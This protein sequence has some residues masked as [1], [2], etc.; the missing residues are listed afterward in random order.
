M[1]KFDDLSFIFRRFPVRQLWPIFPSQLIIN[2]KQMLT[3]LFISIAISEVFA[4]QLAGRFHYL[5]QSS[6]P[7]I[8]TAIKML[9]PSSYIRKR[10][11]RRKWWINVTLMSS[12][13]PVPRNERRWL[14][15]I[16]GKSRHAATSEYFTGT[17]VSTNILAE[18]IIA[19][20][21]HSSL[22]KCHQLHCTRPARYS[23]DRIHQLPV[24]ISLFF[25]IHLPLLVISIPTTTTTTTT[26]ITI[27]RNQ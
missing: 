3:Y 15:E 20:K 9:S 26:T 23:S 19:A 1:Q 16:G 25:F 5:G 4:N 14:T 11:K 13:T 12:E 7:I 24:A 6:D 2:R 27:T 18:L 8:Y 17:Y 22:P 21:L 10:R